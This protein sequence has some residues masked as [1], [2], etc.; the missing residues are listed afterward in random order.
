MVEVRDLASSQMI[1]RNLKTV[2]GMLDR[3]IRE[4]N[5]MSPTELDTSIS[6]IVK[7]LETVT[8]K[9][10]SRTVSEVNRTRRIMERLGVLKGGR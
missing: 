10:F 4:F 7:L 8:S 5:T 3:V 6:D 9:N 2:R 1:L